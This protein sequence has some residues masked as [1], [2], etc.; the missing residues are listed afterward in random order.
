[1]TKDL[2][3]SAS[4]AVVGETALVYLGVGED[5]LKDIWLDRF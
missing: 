1:M 4:G 5:K 2:D 3:V